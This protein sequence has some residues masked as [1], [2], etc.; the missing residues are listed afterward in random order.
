[1]LTIAV[2]VAESSKP[3]RVEIGHD[4]S[5]GSRTIETGSREPAHA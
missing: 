3:R 2:P 4:A 5:E 1:V